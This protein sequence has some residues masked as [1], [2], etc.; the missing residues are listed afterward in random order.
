MIKK[1][2]EGQFIDC[3]NTHIPENVDQNNSFEKHEMLLKCSND[4]GSESNEEASLIDVNNDQMFDDTVFTEYDDLSISRMTQKM[5]KHWR[6][7]F[8]TEDK[9]KNEKKI[10]NISL[11][12]L[13][14]RQEEKNCISSNFLRPC[15]I[16]LQYII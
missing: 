16:A 11:E 15:D 10:D 9:N 14:Q 5:S 13:V 12:E 2:T 7:K 1:V 6:K 8:K 3:P 4:E